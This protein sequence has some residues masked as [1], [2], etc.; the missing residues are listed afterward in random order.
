MREH[1]LLNRILL[2]YEE[3]I[4][5]LSNQTDMR[6]E[7]LASA[8]DIIRR[9]I[10]E[11]HE[12]LEEDRIFPRFEKAGRFV[13]LVQVLREQHDAGRR[14]TKEIL[15]LARADSLRDSDQRKRLAG[16]LSLFVRMY[17][18]HEARED[19]ELFPALHD[20]VSALEVDALGEEFERK[21]HQLFGKQGFE[22]MV[23]K[24]AEIEKA[25]GLYD[26]ARFTPA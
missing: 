18:P 21:E 17:R 23:Q 5:R 13:T 8:A 19:T 4:L 10:E 3:S 25:M 15:G 22:G 1:G 9:F 6:P 11:Y 24:T 14:L 7:H 26:L 2:I 20:I 12:K 16:R